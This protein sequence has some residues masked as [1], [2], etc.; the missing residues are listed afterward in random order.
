MKQNTF[1]KEISP[2]EVKTIDPFEIS[3]IAMK[4]GSIITVTEKNNENNYN[5]IEHKEQ[6]I[7]QIKERNE[8]N[9]PKFNLKKKNYIPY[10]DNESDYNVYYS[11]NN[12][13]TKIQENSNKLNNNFNNIEN[14]SFYSYDDM[15]SNYNLNNNIHKKVNINKKYNNYKVDYIYKNNIIGENNIIKDDNFAKINYIKKLDKEDNNYPYIIEK[16]KFFIRKKIT[17]EEPSLNQNKT[18]SYKIPSKDNNIYIVRNSNKNNNKNK[19]ILLSYSNKISNEN[20]N[21]YIIR[22]NYPKTPEIKSRFKNYMSTNCCTCKRNNYLKNNR[23][24]SEDI[25]LNSRRNS[26]NQIHNNYYKIKKNYINSY[27]N[28]R[29]FQYKNKN[30]SFVGNPPNN[31]II[32]ALRPIYLRAK[33]PEY[34][35]K[36]YGHCYG[37]NKKNNNHLK[38]NKLRVSLRNDNH[39]FYERKELRKREKTSMMELNNYLKSNYFKLTNRNGKTIHVF[40]D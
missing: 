15:Q 22:N 4:D 39:R 2:D 3:Y 12:N 6:N 30:H 14:N 5:I 34:S 10:Q 8:E 9:S 26:N 25:L 27:N 31:L 20:K 38:N 11:N 16:K 18:F 36:N 1:V 7:Y 40:E 13:K 19:N 28:N 35:L 23:K 17:E 33:T 29:V 21:Y 24:L 37:N 32:Q